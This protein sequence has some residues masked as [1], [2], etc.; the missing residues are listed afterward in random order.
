MSFSKWGTCKSLSRPGKNE[1]QKRVRDARN[2]ITSSA[3]FHHVFPAEQGAEQIH[4]ILT[5]ILACFLP[6]RAKNLS[7]LL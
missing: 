7:E 6:G 5:E 2:F 3:S 4:A 1:D